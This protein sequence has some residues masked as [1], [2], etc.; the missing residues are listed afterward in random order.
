MDEVLTKMRRKE[1]LSWDEEKSFYDFLYRR[2]KKDH[3][4]KRSKFMN[5]SVDKDD[6]CQ[7]IILFVYKY[8]PQMSESYSNSIALFFIIG[9]ALGFARNK[10]LKKQKD[11]PPEKLDSIENYRYLGNCNDYKEPADPYKPFEETFIDKHSVN[12]LLEVE[13]L[14]DTNLL[15]SRIFNDLSA[16]NEE[17][18]IKI[19]EFKLLGF[20]DFE[21]S[22]KLNIRPSVVFYQKNYVIWPLL[23]NIIK[24][25]KN[26]FVYD[27]Y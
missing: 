11:I 24:E 14:F 19:L 15:L 21:I 5:Y 25:Y 18:A 10:F 1:R 2:I 23:K 12:S 9:A 27:R 16:R 22:K 7:E 3:R 20:S 17:K 4:F 6:I 8:L 26:D 13:F